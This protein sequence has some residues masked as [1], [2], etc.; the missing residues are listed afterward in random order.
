MCLHWRCKTLNTP[1]HNRNYNNGIQSMWRGD[2]DRKAR[3]RAPILPFC[4]KRR[5]RAPKRPSCGMWRTCASSA[6]RTANS[7]RQSSGR[8]RLFSVASESTPVA[9]VGTGPAGFYTAKY[10][11]AADPNVRVDL[12]DALPTPFGTFRAETLSKLPYTSRG[13]RRPCAEWRSTRPSRSKEC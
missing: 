8:A 12:Y 1:Q 13:A 9:I 3:T 6:V 11:L 5:Q 2:D 10:L 7:L 4:C